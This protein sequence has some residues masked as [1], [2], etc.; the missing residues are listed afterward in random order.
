MQRIPLS[1]HLRYASR[2]GLSLN[3]QTRVPQLVVHRETD[4]LTGRTFSYT[5]KPDIGVLTLQEEHA[6]CVTTISIADYGFR[7]GLPKDV[8]SEFVAFLKNEQA[9]HQKQERR[10]Q[11]L[12]ELF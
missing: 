6:W 5:M 8:Q 12:I 4:L 1:A 3:I 11:M 9:F 10:A 7:W 2:F